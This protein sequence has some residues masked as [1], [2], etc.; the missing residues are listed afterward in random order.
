M[1]KV[2]SVDDIGAKIVKNRVAKGGRG[3]RNIAIKGKTLVAMWK[4]GRVCILD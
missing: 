2:M 3:E 4:K 1:K